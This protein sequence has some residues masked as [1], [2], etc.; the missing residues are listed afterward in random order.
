MLPLSVTATGVGFV[1]AVVSGAFGVGGALVLIPMLLYLPPLVSGTSLEV[2]AV[3]GLSVVL[4]VTA[5]TVG[6]VLHGR[7]G[8]TSPSLV[9]RLGLPM[10]VGGLAGGAGSRVVAAPLL[11]LLFAVLAS[12]GCLLL[13]L[14]GVEDEAG[15]G[16]MAGALPLVWSG[17]GVGLAGGLLGAG[18][19]F[20][21][22]PLMI[23]VLRVPTRLA[24]GSSLAITLLGSSA[25]LVGKVVTDQV[26]VELVPW[27]IA[28]CIP[29]ALLGTRLSHV[30]PAARLRLALAVVIGLVALSTWRDALSALI[31]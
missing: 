16:S 8:Y 26:P 23:R 9:A 20:L 17:L 31:G 28:G 19:A 18:G 3:S 1:G 24:V 12:A 7:K 30:L 22:L 11:L 13:V 5:S 2:Q 4:V 10:V 25:T 29:G 27:A 14:P 15:T 21:L 6:A